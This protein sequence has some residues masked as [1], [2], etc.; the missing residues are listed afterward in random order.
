MTSIGTGPQSLIEVAGHMLS[1]HDDLIDEGE[2]IEDLNENIALEIIRR[3]YVSGTC[4][5]FA[6]ALHDATGY[7]IIGINGSFHLAVRKPD[8]KIV[9]FMGE[10]SL[11]EITE[12]YGMLNPLVSSWSREETVDHVLMGDEEEDP[13][14]DISV[15]KWVMKKLGR[16]E[17]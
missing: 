5:A 9:D 1:I 6:I 13:W 4:G 3:E 11:E 16:W 12:R 10:F 14:S 7:P 8:G 2:E 17:A 15:A